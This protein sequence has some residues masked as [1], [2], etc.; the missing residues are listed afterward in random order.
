MELD[1]PSGSISCQLLVAR[2]IDRIV[3]VV[4][5]RRFT[6]R[7]LDVGPNISMSTPASRGYWLTT[8][9]CR[10]FSVLPQRLPRE[11]LVD[12]TNLSIDIAS[13]RELVT[14]NCNLQGS[15]FGDWSD[16]HL[17]GATSVAQSRSRTND[18]N[19]HQATKGQAVEKSLD[20]GRV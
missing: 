12:S 4:S 19:V 20:V 13:I 8:A 10:V 9:F 16:Q 11:Q 14:Y 3:S 6:L 17:G 18:I 5:P 2:S 7:I 1:Y 15:Q